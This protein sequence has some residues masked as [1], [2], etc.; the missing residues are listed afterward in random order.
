MVILDWM[1]PGMTGIDAAA[2]IRARPQTKSLPIVMI[3]AYA[4]KVEQARSADAGVNV[5]LAK[6]ITASSLF[7]AL[8]EAQG[9][10]VHAVHRALD[11]PLE[12]EFAGVRA[13]LA[14][15]NEANQLVAQEL[16]SRLGIE[17]EIAEN[18]RI[19]VEM[20]RDNPG[21]YAAILM[22]MQMP[23]MDGL[24]ATRLLR[25]DR[26]LAHLPIIAMT[27]NAMRR[28]L[29]ACTAAG[30]N[31]HITKPI[32]RKALLQTLRRWLPAP[33]EHRTDT[34]LG[35]SKT[36]AAFSPEPVAAVPDGSPRL[37]GIDVAGSL[38][39]LGLEFETL[40]RMLVRFADSQGATIDAL[41]AAVASGDSAAAAKHAHA[42][43]G[44]SGNLG[45]EGLHAAAK[46]LE[47]AGR[48]EKR[49]SRPSA[50]RSRRQGRCG[51]PLY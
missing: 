31:D 37:E 9:A 2:R 26:T 19:A 8:V 51:F 44:A 35:A 34:D 28:E 24:E 13:L 10:K 17:L 4:G 3:S 40:R 7:D 48:A 38:A 6:P 21:R 25:A 33:Q 16:L 5:F 41:R 12:R 49:E 20:V 11:V 29:E 42:I 18:G 23:E 1:L 47:R 27:A 30:M 36:A 45:A 32:D 14:E 39:R 22:D 15:D 46:A 43:A 50:C